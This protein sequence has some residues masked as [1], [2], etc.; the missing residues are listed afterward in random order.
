[1]PMFLSSVLQKKTHRYCLQLGATIADRLHLI[2]GAQHRLQESAVPLFPRT[3]FS[4]TWRIL[5][6]TG[7]VSAQRQKYIYIV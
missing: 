7:T 5:I 3:P 4:F 1:M 6:E 2:A